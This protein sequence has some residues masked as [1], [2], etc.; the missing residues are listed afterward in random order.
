MYK[1]FNIVGAVDSSSN[2]IQSQASKYKASCMGTVPSVLLIH[3]VTNIAITVTS[4]HMKASSDADRCHPHAVEFSNLPE[5]MHFRNI[6]RRLAGKAAT[7]LLKNNTLFVHLFA[8]SCIHLF[9]Y[10]QWVHILKT[11]LSIMDRTFSTCPSIIPVW[12]N[13]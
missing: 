4:V 5:A 3:R 10:Y 11:M 13:K 6:R 9:N 12:K 8:H 7:Y 2:C 1:I